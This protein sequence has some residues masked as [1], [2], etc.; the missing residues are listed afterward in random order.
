MI[1]KR[2]TSA[3]GS[4]FMRPEDKERCRR[5]ALEVRVRY[6]AKRGIRPEDLTPDQLEE[7]IS[8]VANHPRLADLLLP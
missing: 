6:C 7:L 2:F 3:T 8:L 5:V 4:E 1:P